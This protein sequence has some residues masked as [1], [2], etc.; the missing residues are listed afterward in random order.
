MGGYGNLQ[1]NQWIAAFGA[2]AFLGTAALLL[3]AI[4]SVV[5]AQVVG[6]ERLRRWSG[7]IGDWL[8]LGHGL[9]GKIC[10]VAVVLVAGYGA[11][12]AAFSISSHEYT[13]KPGEEK[14]FCEIDCHLAYSVPSVE[15]AAEVGGVRA[16]GTFYVVT[17]KTR[18][19]ETTISPRRGDGPLEPSPRGV[20]LEDESGRAIPIAT[21]AQ[22]ALEATSSAGKPLDTP[23]RP[24][25]SYLT[26]L[27][28]DVPAAA[29]NLRLFVA[30]PSSP[31]WLG[32]LIIGEEDSVLHKKTFLA[33]PSATVQLQ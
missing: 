20:S 14:Y 8:F 29:G 10:V 15:Q 16:R 32:A 13:L 9:R 2:L 24:G 23:L 31:S 21:E 18:F 7:A 6:E 25:E 33:L 12:L 4:A 30:S 5:G 19:D 1:W 17:L 3:A 22:R 26:R 28:F 11:T 27:V